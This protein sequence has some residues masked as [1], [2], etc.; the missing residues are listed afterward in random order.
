MA[1]SFG[2]NRDKKLRCFCCR[3]CGYRSNDDRIGAM[4]LFNLGL[5]WIKE[6]TECSESTSLQTG[7][8]SI[9]PRCNDSRL[10]EK[11]V[12]KNVV[13]NLKSSLKSYGSVTSPLA[14]ASG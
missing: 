6:Q 14:L 3:N 12:G 10:S 7:V 11:E 2:S 8:Q 9:T 13:D 4:N 5:N 1:R